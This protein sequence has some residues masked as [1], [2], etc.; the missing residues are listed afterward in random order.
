ML[1]ELDLTCFAETDKAVLLGDRTEADAEW[2]PKSLLEDY[3]TCGESG[4]V[5]MQEWK[6]REVGWT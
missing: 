6:A 5:V 3:P 2:I 4:S 1:I